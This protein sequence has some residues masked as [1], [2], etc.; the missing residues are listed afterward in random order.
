[1]ADIDNDV[2]ERVLRG[3]VSWDDNDAAFVGQRL[4]RG[5]AGP[6]MWRALVAVA[7]SPSLFRAVELRRAEL[8]RTAEFPGGVA[9]R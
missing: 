7:H 8:L 5:D 4:E 2:V 1:M 3:M 9:S 6:A